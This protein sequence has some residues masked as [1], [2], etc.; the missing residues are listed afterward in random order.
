MLFDSHCHLQF[1]QYDSDR[2][3]ILTD[4]NDRDMGL[5]VVGCD[6]ASSEDA[7]RLAHANANI[8]ATVGIHPTD[9]AERFDNKKMKTL[10]VASKKVVAIG[11]TGLDY[12]HLPKEESVRTEQIRVQKELFEAHIDLSHEL[13]MPL[14]I[15]SR[16]AHQDLLAI[17]INRFT[18]P[19]THGKHQVK[20]FGVAHC[21]TGTVL[22]AQAYLDIGFLISFTGILTFTHEYDAVVRAVPLKKILIETDAPFLSPVPHRG[23]RNNPLYVE[24]VARRI[25]EIKEISS[26]EVI[27]TT[28]E[29]TKRLFNIQT[30]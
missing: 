4:C 9:S 10:C 17:L 22:E 21:F 19:S 3:A 8:W 27:Q 23:K 7:I 30:L 2:D 20:E 16:D 24:Y 13:G 6:F 15:H 29:N 26:D 14:V 28:A 11:E 5:V 18:T 1:P 25:A 12:F